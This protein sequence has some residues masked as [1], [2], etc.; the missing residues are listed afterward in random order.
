MLLLRVDEN[1]IDFLNQ[2]VEAGKGL[3]ES[4]GDQNTPVVLA[5]FSSVCY[6]VTDSAHDVL[7]GFSRLVGLLRNNNH[8]WTSLKSTFKR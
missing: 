5:V 6:S 1:L 7:K 8:V 3:E 4:F 2:L